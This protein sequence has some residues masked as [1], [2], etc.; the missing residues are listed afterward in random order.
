MGIMSTLE[1]QK[2]KTERQTCF[3][4]SR[5]STEVFSL[6]SD[7]RFFVNISLGERRTRLKVHVEKKTVRTIRHMKIVTS[8]LEFALT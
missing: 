6:L 7:T 4:E 1:K 5:G 8:S 2:N 3:R